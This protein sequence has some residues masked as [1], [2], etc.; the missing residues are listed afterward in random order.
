MLKK[1]TEFFRRDP[2]SAKNGTSIDAPL[3]A[4]A[5]MLE[6]TWADHETDSTEIERSTALL[7]QLFNLDA[8]VAGQLVDDARDRLQHNVGVQTYT[9]HLNEALCEADKFDVI[10][11]LWRVAQTSN[12]VDRFEEHTIRRIADLL[13]LSH[14][15]FIQAKLLARQNPSNPS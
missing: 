11:A 1:L 15:R 2:D 10:T 12:G 6:V 14:D 5:L 4:A 3:A 7:K 8:A 13:Y 9:R